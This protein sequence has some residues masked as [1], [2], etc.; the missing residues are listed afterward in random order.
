MK[1]TALLGLALAGTRTDTLRVV[2]TAF[3]AALASLAVLAALNVLAIPAP[4]PRHDAGVP[5]SDQYANAL[6]REPGLHIGVVVALLMLTIPVLA[7]AGQCAR[8]GAPARDRRLAAIR[9]AGGTP[10]Q[11][12]AVA[13]AETGVASLL[14]TCAGLVAYLIGHEALHRPDEQG[15]LPLPT[16]VLPPIPAIAAAV[17]GL[18]LLAALAAVVM[19]RRVTVDPLGV[20]R[21]TR[22]RRAPK[23]WPAV[24]IV[25]GMGAFF[26][27]E[28]IRKGYEKSG[29]PAVASALPFLLFVGG[30]LLAAVGVVLGTG[31][32]SHATGRVLHRL[33]RRP[34]PLLAARRLLADPWHGSRTQA[35]LLVAVVFGS[36]AAAVRAYFSTML[37][38]RQ[39]VRRF[40]D[41]AAGRQ[42]TSGHGSDT[43]YLDTMDLV[44][45]AVAVGLVIAT[46]GLLVTVAE[47]VVARR[48]THAALAAT[49]VPRSVLGRALV[50]QTLAPLVPAVALATTVGT[51]MGRGY[52]GTEVKEFGGRAQTCDADPALCAENFEKH[53]RLVEVPDVV[54]AVPLPWDDLALHGLG[55]PVLALAATGVGLLFLRAGTAVEE[56]R[57]G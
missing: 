51:L 35:A 11:T 36:G 37:E 6:L 56:L 7:L 46:A 29:D 55:V 3:S 42:T 38:A 33:A 34:A 27:F 50:W 4:P 9:L 43:F 31:W 53:S 15:R 47:S 41:E 14:G 18:P 49:G 23:P 25:L 22:P 45:A 19:L 8:L 5:V 1:P 13:A 17:L 30:G 57:T 2:L 48:R 28:A 54:R 21:R 52:F 39:E 12:R 32:I 24:L 20:T 10:R 40:Y 44:D 26:A 16:D